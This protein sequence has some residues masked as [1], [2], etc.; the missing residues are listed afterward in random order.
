[1]VWLVEEPSCG[2]M[3]FTAVFPPFLLKVDDYG[4]SRVSWSV[5]E[6]GAHIAG[7]VVKTLDEAVECAME[8]AGIEE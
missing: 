3:Q 6:N 2:Q 1:M 5:F 4:N 7:G 8:R